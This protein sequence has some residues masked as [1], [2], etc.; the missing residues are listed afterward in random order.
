MVAQPKRPAKR[1]VFAVIGLAV[2]AGAGFWL[3]MYWTSRVSLT[4]NLVDSS[5]WKTYTSQCFHYSFKVPADIKAGLMAPKAKDGCQ[6]SPSRT[7]TPQDVNYWASISAEVG[8]SSIGST[9]Q[10]VNIL[11]GVPLPVDNPAAMQFA[12]LESASTSAEVLKRTLAEDK[13]AKAGTLNGR[14][15][16]VWVE[17]NSN[18]QPSNFQTVDTPYCPCTS[19]RVLLDTG[20]NHLLDINAHWLNTDTESGAI[21]RT[22]IAS[23][24][25]R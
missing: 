20:D 18:R 10:G 24:T 23:V 12:G 21:S 19:E 8:T 1:V 14:P 15:A 7:L 5:G 3:Y 25:T 22:I 6:I 4:A 17:V 11:L 9:P 13:T 2:V 16:V